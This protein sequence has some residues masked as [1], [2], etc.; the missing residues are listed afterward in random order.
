MTTT[1][2]R[3]T[4]RPDLDEDTVISHGDAYDTPQGVAVHV[5]TQSGGAHVKLAGARVQVDPRLDAV[6]AIGEMLKQR[7]A[8]TFA[9]GTAVVDNEGDSGL[10]IEERDGRVYVDGGGEK[11]WTYRAD[12][13]TVAEGT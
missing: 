6:E 12:E 1:T 13:L 10:V 2:S 4:R 3:I 7:A 8:V 11:P 5:V 9:P